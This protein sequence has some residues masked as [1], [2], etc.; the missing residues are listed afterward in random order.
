MEVTIS[1]II[2]IAHQ[3]KCRI[4]NVDT[5]WRLWQLDR[6]NLGLA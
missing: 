4:F 5:A 2:T 1:I 6:I 3:S